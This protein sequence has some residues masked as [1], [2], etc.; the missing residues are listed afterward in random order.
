M[1]AV[2]HRAVV[3]K[4]ECETQSPRGLVGPHP[5]SFCFCRFGWGLKVS[6]GMQAWSSRGTQRNKWKTES[7]LIELQPSH[8]S[9]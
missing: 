1:C 3:S 5:P 4:L 8:I 9:D 2:G 6:K 7:K